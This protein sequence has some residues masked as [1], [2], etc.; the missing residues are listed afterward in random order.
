MAFG[1]LPSS[2]REW[3]RVGQLPSPHW[4]PL[5]PS[6]FPMNL[7]KKVPEAAG[8]QRPTLEEEKVTKS[9]IPEAS[10]AGAPELSRRALRPCTL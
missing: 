2:R 3:G 7:G 6:S 10:A 9:W 5:L 1:P 8:S 4:D